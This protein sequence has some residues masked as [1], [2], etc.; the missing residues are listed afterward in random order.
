M[1]C[2]MNLLKDGFPGY[3][4]VQTLFYMQDTDCA[5]AAL[6]ATQKLLQTNCVGF[7]P[8]EFSTTGNCC[9]VTDP[10]THV[11]SK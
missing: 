4:C 10:F 6:L 9:N 8:Q 7:S 5:A 1:F 2:L 11:S 3:V